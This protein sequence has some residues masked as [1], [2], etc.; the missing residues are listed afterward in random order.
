MSLRI[1]KEHDD[2]VQWRDIQATATR[3]H[4]VMFNGLLRRGNS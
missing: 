1:A 4:D 3:L 2:W